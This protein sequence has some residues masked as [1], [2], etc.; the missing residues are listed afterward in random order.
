[1]AN[2][3][4]R[5]PECFVPWS[6]GVPQVVFD[7]VPERPVTIKALIR[8]CGIDFVKDFDLDPGRFK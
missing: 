4:R 2:G 6:Q 5:T 8:K 7:V 1:M 3:L